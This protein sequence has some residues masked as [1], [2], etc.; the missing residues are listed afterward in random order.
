MT[1][2]S[3]S[4]ARSKGLSDKK[5]VTISTRICGSAISSVTK[6]KEKKKRKDKNATGRL[7]PERSKIHAYVKSLCVDAPIDS[8]LT[9]QRK[10]GS[11]QLEYNTGHRWPELI[12]SSSSSNKPM[13]ERR[14]I[15]REYY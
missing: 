4:K 1:R 3:L 9:I 2:S 15:R 14:R 13:Y 11:E 5:S 6:W 8:I 7:P 10:G 12:Y